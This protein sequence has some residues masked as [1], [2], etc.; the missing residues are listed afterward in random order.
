MA[1]G[2]IQTS[3]PSLQLRRLQ[4]LA[5]DLDLGDFAAAEPPFSGAAPSPFTPQSPAPF[6]PRARNGS[7]ERC[8]AAPTWWLS[9]HAP[10]WEGGDGAEDDGGRP[11]NLWED[12]L[13]GKAPGPGTRKGGS[14][15]EIGG[16][17]LYED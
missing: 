1:A 9:G 7:A 17:G 13:E 15:E 4:R 14:N 6:R 8:V 10:G 12:F 3:L 2:H 11:G 5:L 16:G